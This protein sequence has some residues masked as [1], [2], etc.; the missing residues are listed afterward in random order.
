MT[1]V[2]VVA[3]NTERRLLQ[4]AIEGMS[5]DV[6]VEIFD[7]PLGSAKYRSERGELKHADDPKINMN[8]VKRCLGRADVVIGDPQ[9]GQRCWIAL[10]VAVSLRKKF[11]CVY[12]GFDVEQQRRLKAA[13]RMT[14]VFC[15]DFALNRWQERVRRYIESGEA[16]EETQGMPDGEVENWQA[17]FEVASA[18][19]H[20]PD[21]G[22]YNLNDL[23]ELQLI[24][25]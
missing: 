2:V 15:D 13:A 12:D 17:L 5:D 19:N 18:M 24:D 25:F 21:T 1:N 14:M 11:I 7:A 22:F 3:D 4:E 9:A 20:Y 16:D 10:D 8:D 6:K 23:R